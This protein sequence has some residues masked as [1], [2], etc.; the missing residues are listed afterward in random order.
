MSRDFRFKR[1]LLRQQNSP[2][3]LG[4]DAVLL[5]AWCACENAEYVTDIG[6][7][8]GVIALMAAQR[9]AKAKYIEGIDINAECL[10]DCDLNFKQSPWHQV[11]KA[12]NADIRNYQP[13]NSQD[14][15]LSNPPYFENSTL[16]KGTGRALARNQLELTLGDLASWASQYLAE[17]GQLELVIPISEFQKADTLFKEKGL[18]LSRRCIVRPR[19]D[20]APK[21]VLLS[22]GWQTGLKEDSQ[23]VIELERHV[24]SPEFDSLCKDFYLAL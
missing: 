24:Y 21:R 20:K 22:Y 8:T 9:G 5:G 18:M 19:P 4:T 11:L 15:I 10:Q 2:M 14:L 3:K 16:A 12:V 7:G 23:L 1:F 6:T 17:K 13:A